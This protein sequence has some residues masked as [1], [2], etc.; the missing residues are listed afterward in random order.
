M[1]YY[2]CLITLS[3]VTLIRLCVGEDPLKDFCRRFGHQ[4]AIVDRKLY[5]DG[6]L[7][8]WSPIA[9]NPVNHTSTVA[10]SCPGLPG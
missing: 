2:R 1:G 3:V 5:I 4:T 6:G 8:N 9:A 10:V 7:L